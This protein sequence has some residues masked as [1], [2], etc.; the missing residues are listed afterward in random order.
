[1]SSI[2][3]NPT[4]DHLRFV[5]GKG[6]QVQVWVPDELREQV[7]IL[8]EKPKPVA[9]LTKY[10][11]KSLPPPTRDPNGKLVFPVAARR[12]AAPVDA[13]FLGWIEK[14]RLGR[15][16]QVFDMRNPNACI[17]GNDWHRDMASHRMI[18]LPIGTPGLV[19]LSDSVYLIDDDSAPPPMID[20]TPNVALDLDQAIKDWKAVHEKTYGA[21]RN[22]DAEKKATDAKLR[23]AESLFEFMETRDF[24]AMKTD[25]LQHWNDSLSPGHAY[26]YGND[27]K[28]LLSALYKKN[29]F[30]EDRANPGDK[31]F[32]PPK[33]K[34]DDRLPFRSEDAARILMAARSEEPAIRWGQWCAAYTGFITSEMFDAKASEITEING[35][36]VWDCRGR[37]LKSAYRPRVEPLHS[38]LVTEGFVNY[39]RSRGDGMLFDITSAQATNR[40][41]AHIRGLGIAGRQWVHYSWRHDFTS[42][43]DRFPDKVSVALG[44]L[45]TGHASPLVK[46]KHYIHKHIHEMAD[47]VELIAYPFVDKIAA[48]A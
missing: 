29:R 44:N 11:D 16:V 4:K 27:V 15:T 17:I 21:W 46:E 13:Q 39:A 8:A 9:Q 23:A 30:G 25:R 28:A 19:K 26:Y 47:A 36:P 35:V 38:A 2:G 6:Y 34:G 18:S 32:I 48:A 22:P 3:V 20:V 42:Q 40:L 14:A 31:L 10:L 37:K 24:G 1:M 12:A 7:A 43:L 41:M 5:P 45:L 33:P